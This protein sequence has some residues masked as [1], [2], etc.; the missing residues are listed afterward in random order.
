VQVLAKDLRGGSSRSL[1][2]RRGRGLLPPPT[3]NDSERHTGEEYLMGRL[4][5][6]AHEGDVTRTRP[7]AR[8]PLLSEF[9][10]R[11]VSSRQVFEV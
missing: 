3:Y 4:S 2:T 8:P 7:E 1:H 9:E 11:L 5:Q 6:S 10:N